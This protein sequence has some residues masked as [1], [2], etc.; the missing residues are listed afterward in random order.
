MV[1]LGWLHF[2]RLDE[3][4]FTTKLAHAQLKIITMYLSQWTQSNDHYYVPICHDGTRLSIPLEA[5]DYNFMS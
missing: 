4:A 2:E 3:C 5:D 1:S